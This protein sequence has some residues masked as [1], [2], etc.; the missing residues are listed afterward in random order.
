MKR[1]NTD[2]KPWYEKEEFEGDFDLVQ[3][4]NEDGTTTVLVKKSAVQRQ[5]A[6]KSECSEGGNEYPLDV[7]FLIS[8]YIRPENVSTFAG[9]T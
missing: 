1:L 3:E 4:E 2:E 6:I 7:W 5:R 9:K 8:E